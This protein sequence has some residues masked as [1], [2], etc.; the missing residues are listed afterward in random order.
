MTNDTDLEGDPQTFGGF[1]NASGTPVVSGTIT[2]FALDGVTPAGSL[3]VNA[4]GSYTFDPLPGFVGTVSIPYSISDTPV[5][6]VA[7]ATDIAYLVIT[8]SPN[9]LTT[10]SVSPEVDW[11]TSEW[12][13]HIEMNIPMKVLRFNFIMMF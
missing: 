10:N 13:M 1:L 7:A 11:P 3:I 5:A 8:V 12:I 2:V 6:A 4:N 9:P